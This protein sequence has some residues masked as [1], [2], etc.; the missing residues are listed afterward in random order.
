MVVQL[1]KDYSHKEEFD[2]NDWD[3]NIREGLYKR[4]DMI[5]RKT[6]HHSWGFNDELV[7]FSYGVA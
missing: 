4:L 7:S 1:A 3:L 6:R 2:P 5:D